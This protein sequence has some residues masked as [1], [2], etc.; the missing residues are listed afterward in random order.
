[1]LIPVR[2]TLSPDR[3]KEDLAWGRGP[4]S[5]LLSRNPEFK[6]YQMHDPNQDRLMLH[7]MAYF[8]VKR[9]RLGSTYEDFLRRVLAPGGPSSCSNARFAGRQHGSQTG[10]IFR[11]AAT[12]A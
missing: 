6:V 2:R 8:R 11:W 4:A 5:E 12:A 9:R 1:M 10:T 3:L 7:H